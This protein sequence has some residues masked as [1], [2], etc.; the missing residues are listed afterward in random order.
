M[1]SNETILFC[2]DPHGRFQHILDAV[3]RLRP[4]AVVLLGDME[5]QKPLHIELESIAQTEIWFIHGNHDTDKSASWDNL[6]G[7]TLADRNIHGRVVELPNGIRLA[8]LGG[9]F[10]GLVWDP[11]LPEPSFRNRKEHAKAT[12]R[13]DRWRDSVHRKH[14]STIYPDEI[15]RLADMRA[16]ILITHEATAYH[17]N[18][19]SILDALA[20]SMGA[21][22]TVHGHHHDRLDSSDH[23]AKQGF[24]SFGVGL[25]GITAIDVEG[26]ADVIVSGELDVQRNCRQKYID[27]VKDLGQ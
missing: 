23:W 21:K 25:R 17:H 22:V 4:M 5:P 11:R 26:N 8:G 12:P 2:G 10:R 24:K 9:V 20:Q 6:W 1:K 7:S 14:W 16:D 27:V 15:N 19:F 18:G 13:Q 3:G